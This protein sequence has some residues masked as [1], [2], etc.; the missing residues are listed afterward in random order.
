MQCQKCDKH[1]TVHL[2]EIINGEKIERHLCEQCAQKE[3]IAIKPQGSISELLGNLIEAQEQTHELSDMSCPQCN[4]SWSQF[5]KEGL[6]GC[7]NDYLAFE[8]PLSRLIEK[9]QD[10]A[11]HHVG[12]VPAHSSGK[13]AQ[14]LKLLTLRK[15]LKLALDEEDYEDAVRLRDEIRKCE[16]N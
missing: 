12:R 9:T 3:G 15:D 8:K 16:L 7:P 13:L 6:L 11:D 2:T 1:A 14:Q 10:G 4:I 5:R